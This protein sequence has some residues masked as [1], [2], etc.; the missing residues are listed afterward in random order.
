MQTSDSNSYSF[1]QKVII[2][3]TVSF[4]LPVICL[5][6]VYYRQGILPFGDRTLLVEDMRREYVDY[7]SYFQSVFKSPENFLYTLKLGLGGGSIGLFTF[8][9]SSPFL[10]PLI[11]IPQELFPVYISWMVLIK[12]GLCG[13]TMSLYLQHLVHRNTGFTD[14]AVITAGSAA[15][16]LCSFFTANFLNTMWID[17]AIVFPLLLVCHENM[18]SKEEMREN[19]K[20]AIGYILCVSAILYLNYYIA[21]MM[22]LFT[23]IWTLLRGRGFRHLMQCLLATLEGAALMAF[24]MLPTYLSIRGSAKDAEI[25]ADPSRPQTLA[26]N[27]LLLQLRPFTF[28]DGDIFK[29]LPNL[30]CGT[31]VAAACLI[32]FLRRKISAREKIKS[33]V[34]IMILAGSLCSQTLTRIWHAGMMPSGYLYRFSFLLSFMMIRCAVLGIL[35]TGDSDSGTQSS[36]RRRAVLEA[37]PASAL[38]CALAAVQI[39]ELTWNADHIYEIFSHAAPPSQ[40][41]FSQEV[42]A[43]KELFS[44]ILEEDKQLYRMETA[45]PFSENDDL[46]YG[47][48]GVTH[49]SSVQQ[50]TDREFLVEMGFNDTGLLAEYTAENTMAADALLGIRYVVYEDHLEQHPGT[51]PLA[52]SI[53]SGNEGETVLQ[54][55]PGKFNRDGDPFVFTETRLR[56]AAGKSP[57]SSPDAPQV[58]YPANVLD[59]AE[60]ACV[61]EAQSDGKVYLY[62]SGT[63]ENP[64]DI[65]VYTGEEF[66]GRFGN[67][68]CRSV[69]CLG[70][71]HKGDRIPLRMENS[72]VSVRQEDLHVVSEDEA[73]VA[74]LTEQAR[75]R[76]LELKEIT[77]SHYQVDYYCDPQI[78]ET[79]DRLILLIPYHPDWHVKINNEKTAPQRFIGEFMS[80]PLDT[81][82]PLNGVIHVDLKFLPA[83]WIPGIVISML[84][85]LAFVLYVLH[86]H[87]EDIH[88]MTRHCN[89]YY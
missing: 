45:I 5:M 50:V 58:F 66:I 30:Y 70:S 72:T 69:L 44:A 74:L 24:L 13:L 21:Y 12:A 85:L 77:S 32:F 86:A 61:I 60:N 57:F 73:A 36:L 11:F 64:Q 87:K 65:Q 89:L 88:V 68:D 39:A 41:A 18:L 79:R 83:G 81:A 76:E 54:E 59:F 19:R 37:W 78:S 25:M 75:S 55:E 47:Y 2:Q 17:A 29:G 14:S 48:N 63:G 15:Y 49:Y 38:L 80:I 46:M 43:R 33:G 67:N 8:Y 22:L 34:M 53:S 56:L 1:R 4:L 7:Y 31:L 10:L 16:S 28:S 6:I 84:A 40:T 35:G 51:L 42:R 52:F 3:S 71:Y 62:I 26:V 82:E 27:Q 9:L 20:W 23:A